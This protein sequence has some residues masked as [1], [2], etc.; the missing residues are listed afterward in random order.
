M[1]DRA[2]NVILVTGAGGQLGAAVVDACADAGLEAIG[3]GHA[4]FDVTD[5]GR[6]ESIVNKMRPHSVI[7][8]AAWTAVDDAQEQREAAFAVN[9]TGTRN[10]ARAAEAVGARFVT[11]STDYVFPGTDPAG[12]AEGDTPDPINVYGASKLA[13]EIAAVEEAPAALIARTAWLFA[14]HGG[15]FVRT[16][17][18]LCAER[19]SID[20]VDDQVGS[21]TYA[22]HLARA[23]VHAVSDELTGVIHLAGEPSATWFDVAVATVEAA[24]YSCGVRRT[25]SDKFPRPAARPSCSILRVTRD[26]TPTVGDWREGVRK[27]VQAYQR[28]PVSVF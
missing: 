23:L 6:V 24:G 22:P 19:E 1:S 10:V 9:E 4:A 17:L 2:D 16:M 18:G 14:D 7:H 11:I 13:S 12:V 3:L 25:T 8:C 15:N 28:G 26:D 21:P 5:R 20:V 27:V